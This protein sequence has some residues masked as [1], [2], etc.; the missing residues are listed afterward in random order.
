[1]ELK[2][3]AEDYGLYAF[4]A[5]NLTTGALRKLNNPAILH[6]KADLNSRDYNHYILFLAAENNQAKILDIPRPVESVPLWKLAA[7]WDG[8][9]L[10]LSK[11]PVRASAIFASSRL[12]FVIYMLIAA[13]V[14]IIIKITG[15]QQW[16]LPV[17]KSKKQFILVSLVQSCLLCGAGIIV[18]ITY[19]FL[20]DEGFLSHVESVEPMIHAHIS[21]F[22]PK[23]NST[24]VGRLINTD[25]IF[26]DARYQQDFERGHIE[27]AVNIPPDAD[28][29]TRMTKLADV[30]KDTYI[31][32]YCQSKSCTFA[33]K[34]AEKLVSDGFSNVAI[35]NEGWKDW[36]ANLTK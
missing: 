27:G 34:I 22:I 35:Y 2:K 5:E 8:K 29:E 36:R 20:N 10:I 11:A 25:A 31:V 4:A 7:R 32:V 12:L 14:I 13:G 1:M 26:V 30:S 6:V 15:R 28:D 9:G 33:S 18:G 24:E 21:D 3:A 17:L 19:H 16:I 23:I